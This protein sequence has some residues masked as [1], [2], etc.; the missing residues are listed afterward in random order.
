[1][2]TR[3]AAFC[4]GAQAISPLILG[5]IPFA[6]I[7]GIAA[8]GAGLSRVE[9]LGMSYIVFAGAAQLAVVELI[10]QQAPATVIILTALVINLRFFMYSAS[11]A[12]HLHGLPLTWRGGLAYLLTDQAFAV[13]I[14]AFHQGRTAFK[15]WYYLGAALTMWGVW[16]AGTAAGVFL[17]AQI[18]ESWSLDFAIPL[19]FLALLVPSLKDRP[20]I[21]AAVSAGFFALIAHGLPYNLGLFLAALG[22][23]TAGYLAD[24]RAKRAL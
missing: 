17:G 18:P 14:A 5:V 9:A 24:R 10:G 3:K 22:G 11:L 6:L 4:A 15:H 21:I 7:A 20:A 2:P 23:I 19:T 12:P 8:M 13:A 1:M 16:Q